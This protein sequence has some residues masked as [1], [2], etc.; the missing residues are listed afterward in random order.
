MFRIKEKTLKGYTFIDLFCGVGGF[1]LALSSF[2]ARC[3][4]A[5]DINQSNCKVYERN[6]NLKPEGDIRKIKDEDIPKHDILC[7]GFPCQAF[8]ISGKQNGFRDPNGK[9]FFEIIRIAKSHKPKM[10]LLENVKNLENHN[11]G[12]TLRLIKW[13]LKRIGYR[14]HCKVLD[15]S[16]FG[17]PQ[18]RKRLYIVAFRND[19]NS[20]AFMFPQKKGKKK[21]LE[22]I[23]VNGETDNFLISKKYE[24]DYEKENNAVN[25]NI[26]L[27]IGK[28]GLGRQGERIYSVKG[29]AITLS[30]QGG[31]VGGKTGMYYIN[32][33]VRKLFP[34]ECA[35]LMGFPDN[36][37]L[38]DIV[39]E[40]YRQFGNS[41]VVN[42]LQEIVRNAS[43]I[44]QE[45][46]ENNE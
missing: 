26:P 39:G 5:S 41:V 37:V 29:Q 21:I 1:H 27:R 6:F 35:R 7:A 38:S 13:K 31:G 4:F 17:V 42:V 25:V 3:V 24:I 18:A 44:L 8:S 11:D 33:E 46:D 16:N 28:V 43:T 40:S 9:L 30:A 45:G 22:D 2:G 23:L 36:Y 34:R 12:K 32:G 19:F 15:S 10:I 20:E 14:A